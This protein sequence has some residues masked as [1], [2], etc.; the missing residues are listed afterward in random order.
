MRMDGHNNILTLF[1]KLA[2][3]MF[4][5]YADYFKIPYGF[6]KL[7]MIALEEFNIGENV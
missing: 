3:K 7:D 5:F 2:L 4:P 1:Q 6:S